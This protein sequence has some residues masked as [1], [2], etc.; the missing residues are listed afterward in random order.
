[1]KVLLEQVKN[2][3]DGATLDEAGRSYCDLLFQMAMLNSGFSID[4]P[5]DL[6]SPLEKL[7]RV[8]F[9]VDRDAA[10]EEIEIEVEEDEEPEL[11]TSSFNYEDIMNGENVQILNDGDFKMESMDDSY[12]S[13][14]LWTRIENKSL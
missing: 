5:T 8:G 3:E 13:E 7:I 6:T 4:E 14:E 2:S 10:V 11:D 12:I 9:G 1:M